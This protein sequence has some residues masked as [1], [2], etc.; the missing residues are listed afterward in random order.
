MRGIP[1]ALVVSLNIEAYPR[2]CMRGASGR[3]GGGGKE[4]QVHRSCQQTYTAGVTNILVGVW[5]G[6]ESEQVLVRVYGNNT[7]L[8][9]DRQQEIDTMKVTHKARYSQTYPPLTS[10][11][12]R[13]QSGD[14]SGSHK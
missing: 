14:K 4:A 12:S 11:I 6:K 9:I 8:F 1:K 7:H 10:A 2:A 5:C 3:G 13:G